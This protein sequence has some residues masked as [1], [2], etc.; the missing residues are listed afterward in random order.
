MYLYLTHS[1]YIL[2]YSIYDDGYLCTMC[3][4]HL[5]MADIMLCTY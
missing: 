5:M 2:L 3:I 4:I 1:F